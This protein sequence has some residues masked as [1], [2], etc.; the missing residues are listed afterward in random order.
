[1]TGYYDPE[2][3]GGADFCQEFGQSNDI[4]FNR[5]YE[6]TPAS[7]RI[8]STETFELIADL[9]PL[10][11]GHLLLLPRPHFFSFAQVV[12]EH[13]DSVTEFLELILPMYT[14]TFA[15]PTILEHGSTTSDDHNACITHAHWHIVPLESQPILALAHRDGLEAVELEGLRAL[16]QLPWRRSAYYFLMHG[17]SATAYVPKIN[18]PRQYIRSLIGRTLG[19][20]D[21]E[22]DYALIVRKQLLRQTIEMTRTWSRTLSL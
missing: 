7:R 20:E 13:H 19:L 15:A 16:G 9:S 4:A 14:L 12:A 18:S 2:F 21:P 10:T 6:G 8:L 5:V 17:D 11:V 22:W 1:M 3:C